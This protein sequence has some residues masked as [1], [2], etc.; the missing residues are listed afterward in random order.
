MKI[1]SRRFSIYTKDY[2]K[3]LGIDS[4]CTLMQIK[5]RYNALVKEHHPD[6]NPT[7]DTYFK[8]INEAYAI[9]VKVDERKKYDDIIA[10]Y[11]LH[12]ETQSQSNKYQNDTN[13][14][15]VN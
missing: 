10:R 11:G 12:S 14:G 4:K 2:Y 6:I 7:Q 9:L 8:D 5:K 15:K 1:V 13:S 3:I